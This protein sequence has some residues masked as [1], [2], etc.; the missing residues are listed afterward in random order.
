MGGCFQRRWVRY[1]NESKKRP[2]VGESLEWPISMIL[3]VRVAVA[4][5]MVAELEEVKTVEELE[6]LEV[7]ENESPSP[8]TSSTLRSQLAGL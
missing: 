3:L 1:C 2:G 6:E 7:E 8:Q 4:A 5:A